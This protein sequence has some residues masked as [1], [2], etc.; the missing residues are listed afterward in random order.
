M[1]ARWYPVKI[2]EEPQFLSSSPTLII[3]VI[4]SSS[5]LIASLS[6]QLGVRA[7]NTLISQELIEHLVKIGCS[8]NFEDLGVL[9]NTFPSARSGAFMRLRPEAWK[10]V[11]DNITHEELVCLIKSLTK[12]ESYKN[13]KAGSV[14]PVICLYRFLTKGAEHVALV[15]WILNNTENSYLPFGSSNHGA[16]SLDD[17][18]RRCEKVAQRQFERQNAD[19]MRQEEAKARKAGE[20]SHRLFGAMRRKD[21]L[22]VVALLNRGADPHTKNDQGQTAIEFATSLG[23]GDWFDRS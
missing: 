20:V 8:E 10:Q 12:L 17:Y 1:S 16:K 21:Q 22:A 15:D 4:T 19:Q 7:M 11:V 13:F 14:S 23:E 18:Q 9:V 3:T 6:T 5:Y 2:K